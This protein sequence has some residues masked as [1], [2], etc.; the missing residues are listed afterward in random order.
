[1]AIDEKALIDSMASMSY[2]EAHLQMKAEE[3]AAQSAKKTATVSLQP[4]HRPK[5]S[6]VV[7]STSSR[8]KEAVETAINE[9]DAESLSVQTVEK[10]DVKSTKK[11]DRHEYENQFLKKSVKV[12][13]NKTVYVR[14]E[15]HADLLEIINSAGRGELTLVDYLDNILEHHFNTYSSDIV[16]TIKKNSRWR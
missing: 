9:E 10:E 5:Q 12:S 1:M 8:K 2:M 13:N 7:A 3:A 14:A 4:S 15:Y 16:R 11:V 6:K